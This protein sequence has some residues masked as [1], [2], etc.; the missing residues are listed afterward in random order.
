MATAFPNGLDDFL[1]PSPTTQLPG[2]G[3]PRLKHSTQHQDINDSVEAV[4][5][6][7]GVT[8]STVATS[9]EYRLHN[10]VNGHDHDGI[11]SR[12]AALGPPCSG[13]TYGPG[14]FTFSTGSR[15]GCAID[16]IN[17]FL[18]SS[19][20]GTLVT[21]Q[22]EGVNLG[23]G[24]TV[25][26]VDFEGTGVSASTTGG[27]NTALYTI[28]RGLISTDRELILLMDCGGPFEGYASSFNEKTYH[29]TVFPSASVWYT[30]SSKS[31][32]IVEKQAV[33]T[34]SSKIPDKNIYR[35]YETDGTTIKT[36]V[37]DNI[38]YN[39]IFEVSRSRTI[40]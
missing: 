24:G 13:T 36:T 30:D 35:V 26:I 4:E 14:L 3:N 34:G 11:N 5:A 16:L 40:L 6:Q 25:S 2:S 37:V 20:S 8:G 10:V 1:N 27:G 7:V 22:H 9:M 18:S 33:Y 19:I 28:T 21:F 12:P 31:A 17:Q 39:G 23:D 38:F 32:R 29:A 15:G